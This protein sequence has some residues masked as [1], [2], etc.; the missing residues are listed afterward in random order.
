MIVIFQ[1][2]TL[3]VPVSFEGKRL[4]TL[5][6]RSIKNLVKFHLIFSF[7]IPLAAFVKSGIMD[8][9]YHL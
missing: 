2:Q 7:I 4:I 9:D 3:F 1:F 5:P 6:S 8:V